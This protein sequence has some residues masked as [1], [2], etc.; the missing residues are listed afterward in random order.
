MA[1]PS[2]T[3]SITGKVAST[4][5]TAPRSPAQ[6]STTRSC[7]LKSSRA[8]ATAAESGRATNTRISVS[9]VPSSH[10]SPRALGKTSRPSARNIVICA[11]HA[12]PSWNTVTVCFAGMRPDPST[13][14]AMYA[15]RKPDPCSVAAPP[16][17]RPAADRVATGY[18]P[19]LASRTRRSAHTA[20][21]PTAAPTSAP[22][23]ISRANSA[24]M[25]TTP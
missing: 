10:T 23:P 7:Q 5:G 3:L 19:V 14:P 22:I 20:S 4:T 24:S 8:V 17:A 11:T 9:T 15:A 18:S 13:R 2:G 6:P 25:S 1:R 21:H 16:K 12:S